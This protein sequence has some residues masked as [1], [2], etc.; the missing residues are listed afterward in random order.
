MHSPCV[1]RSWTRHNYG[2]SAAALWHWLCQKNF[3]FKW[4]NTRVFENKMSAGRKNGKYER[5]LQ[6]FVCEWFTRNELSFTPEAFPI[7]VTSSCDLR[8]FTLQSA[9]NHLAICVTSRAH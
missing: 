3:E 9:S 2:K 5:L 6:L 7:C 8:H 4:G 1:T